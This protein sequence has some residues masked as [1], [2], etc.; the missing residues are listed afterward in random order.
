[1]ERPKLIAA[2]VVLG[3]LIAGIALGVAGDRVVCDS[4]HEH[5]ADSRTYWDRIGKEWALTTAQ[6]QV[7]DSLMDAQRREITAIYA[8]LRPSLDSASARAR[9]VSDS[10]MAHLRLVLTPEQREKLD[11][12]RAD[13]RRR[14]AAFRARRDEDLSKIR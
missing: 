11:A 5:V 4:R 10:T 6:R 9:Q 8:P 2:L 3:A 14:E 12:M 13:A 1:M 7:I